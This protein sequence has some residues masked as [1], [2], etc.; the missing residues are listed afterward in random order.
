MPDITTITILLLTIEDQWIF[1]SNI[2]QAIV[3]HDK[4]LR[5]QTMI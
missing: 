5:H 4:V 1:L 2:D 3:A